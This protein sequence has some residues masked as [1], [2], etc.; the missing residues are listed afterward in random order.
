MLNDFALGDL[1]GGAGRI[2]NKTEGAGLGIPR[3]DDTGATF[4]AVGHARDD[5]HFAQVR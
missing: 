4:T 5:V 3:R 1:F 2:Q